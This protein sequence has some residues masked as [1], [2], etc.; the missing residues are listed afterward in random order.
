M[1]VNKAFAFLLVAPS[2]PPPS[3]RDLYHDTHNTQFKVF[4][5]FS[6]QKFYFFVFGNPG[7]RF[8]EF[9]KGRVKF[10]LQTGIY[11][12]LPISEEERL[13]RQKEKEELEKEKRREQKLREQKE[14]EM[15]EKAQK[16]AAVKARKEKAQAAKTAKA[17]FK[18][19]HSFFCSVSAN[20]Y[21]NHRQTGRL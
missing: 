4:V 18:V 20:Y 19:V 12:I 17:T 21:L 3:P 5:L 8:D 10:S 6:L 16:E 14:K 9:D 2:P 11:V 15:K 7:H 13:R 1:W